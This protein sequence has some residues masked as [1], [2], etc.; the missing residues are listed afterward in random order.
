[1][2]GDV[3]LG[4][5]VDRLRVPVAVNKAGQLIVEVAHGERLWQIDHCSKQLVDDV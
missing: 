4:N 2:A 1:M 5:D 3:Q